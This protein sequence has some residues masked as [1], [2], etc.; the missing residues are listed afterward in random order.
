M[1]FLSN[2]LIVK[3][4]VFLSDWTVGVWGSFT[5]RYT[6]AAFYEEREEDFLEAIVMNWMF[7]PHPQKLMLNPNPNVFG[8]SLQQVI[9]VRCAHEGVATMMGL[10]PPYKKRYQR[11]SLSLC[12]NK[13]VT[14]TYSEMVVAYKPRRGLR[15]NLPCQ[16]LDLRLPSLQNCKK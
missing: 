5:I 14:C 4:F 10:V 11:A 12:A 1:C 16:N 3:S 2:D 8:S 13:I 7:V 9:R 6:H 15:W